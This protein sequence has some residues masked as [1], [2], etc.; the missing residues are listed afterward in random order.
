M[1]ELSAKIKA[2]RE[3]FMEK[4][5]ERRRGGLSQSAGQNGL[6]GNLAGGGW[7]PLRLAAVKAVQAQCL[8]RCRESSATGW[9]EDGSLWLTLA[10][11]APCGHAVP[12][13][14]C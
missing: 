6:K 10:A 3:E 12:C 11:R 14:R 1:E 5:M 2:E 13:G 4:L 9:L 7:W 8:V